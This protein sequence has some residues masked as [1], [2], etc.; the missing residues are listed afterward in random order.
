M[1]GNET[2]DLKLPALSKATYQRWSF[3]VKSCARSL[4]VLSIVD[5][6]EVRPSGQNREKE[7]MEWD[8]RDGKACRIL[9]CGLSDD[10]HT[11]IRDCTSAN[12]IWLKIKSMYEQRTSENKYLLQQEFFKL[13]FEDSETVSSYCAKLLVLSQK[14]KTVGEEVTDTALVSKMV[15]DLPSKYDHFK[16][17]YMIQAAAGTTLTFEKLREQLLI[18]EINSDN[19]QKSSD[20]NQALTV[21]IKPDNKKKIKEKRECYHC[22]KRG[23]L[24]RDC[25]K[26]KS[27]KQSENTH[28]T[29]SASTA[30]SLS[31][32]VASHISGNREQDWLADSGASHHMSMNRSWFCNFEP[33]TENR[34]A[35]TVGNNNVVYAKG[36]GSVQ[37]VAHVGN[38]IFEHCL[39]N[40]LYV[41]EIRCN[42]FSLGSAADNGIEARM[43][44]ENLQLMRNNQVVAMGSRVSD[45]LYALHFETQNQFKASIAEF[46]ASLQTWHERCGHCSYKT[47]REMAKG[48]AVNGMVVTDVRDNGN[49]DQF[50]EACVFGKHS[51]K[52]FSESDTRASKPAELIHF[53]I[54]G[55]MSV[56]SFG[57]NKL[58]AVFCDDYTSIVNVYAIKTKSEIVDRMADMIS[59]ANAAGHRIHRVRSDNAKEF[60]SK[61]MNALLRK[62]S[63]VHEY[64]VPYCA[65]QNGRIERQN[66]TIVEMARSMLAGA[67]LP[68]ELWAEACKTAAL[69]RNMLPL[70][71]LKGKTPAELWTGKKPD[72]GILRIYG[73]KA[74]AHVSKQ[75][76]SK[77]EPKS[78]QMLLVGY[79]PKSKAYR[80]W[81]PGTNRVE[82]SRDAIIVEPT[83]K[84]QAVLVPVIDVDE[85]RDVI[86]NEEDVQETMIQQVK[87]SM[88]E[89]QSTE[90]KQ[91]IAQRTRSQTKETPHEEFVSSRT[92]SKASTHFAVVDAMAFIANVKVPQTVEEARTLPD[93]DQWE[94]SMTT[95][96][97]ALEQNNT[98]TLVEP[99]VN[100]KP[101]KNK[102]VF[103]I[104]TNPDGSLDKYKA[105]LVIKGC[106]LRKGVDFDQTYSPVTR[107]E[108]VRIL[109]SIAAAN[110]FELYQM[111]VKSAFLNGELEE[112]IFMEQPTGFNDGTERVC[113]LNKA[114]YG[115]PQAPRAWNSRFDTFVKGFGLKA[116]NADPCVYSNEEGDIY[117]TLWVDDGLVLGRSKD[118]IEELLNAMCKEFKITSSI[119]KYYLGIKIERD[120]KSKKIRLTQ[121]AYARTIL[122]KFEMLECNSAKTPMEQGVQLINNVDENGQ[123]ESTANVPYR[124]IIGSLMYLAVSTRPDLSYV[125]GV[126]SRFLEQPSAS[127]WLTAKRVLKYIKGT[128][129]VGITYNGNCDEKN[130][131]VAFSDSD[132]ASCVNTRKSTSGVILIINGGPVVWSSRKQSVVATSTT[133]AEYI[134]MCE[135][136]KEVVWTRRLLDELRIYQG[137]ATVIYCDN[138]AAKLLVENPVYHRRTKHIDV[139]FHY[140]REQIK[141][142]LVEVKHVESSNQLA[143]FLTKNLS[144]DRFKFNCSLLGLL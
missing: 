108:S 144:Y 8:K 24:K 7:V 76:R 29:A 66:R 35:I 53:D 59:E 140:T 1:M 10:D 104:K 112:D 43:N 100:C 62:H 17:T 68:L 105:R 117:L 132:Y 80:L 125:V 18:I 5:G 34:I 21:K 90:D 103:R 60:T 95:E 124:Q 42:L 22:G 109:L 123:H 58:L 79:E 73:S 56:E 93:K 92:R 14:L 16:H 138:A 122:E 15:N 57:K 133:D 121:T 2:D 47:I 118:K 51:R 39:V 63:I 67:G 19:D 20:N 119:A 37:V 106:S 31:L 136:A 115:L 84:Q 116:T 72:V 36:R 96:I 86:S 120:R 48:E 89:K 49:E 70:K 102:W 97:K 6:S 46:G 30:N 110:D 4:G 99:P 74:Y 28:Q 25:R 78:K 75:F 71:R 83:L 91:P 33:I 107:L 12:Q 126:L 40:V 41:P 131:L 81:L 139:K 98:Y 130:R 13:K 141:N 55:P 32:M 23:H 142:G 94:Q 45:R 44:K 87:E 128:L 129:E 113:K 101:V 9:T 88:V 82:I 134:A 61:E 127:H 85:P 114:L 143:D 111:D 77:F 52:P 69:I 38:K 137:Q 27:E 26:L 64:S 54:C 135:A 65:A 11:A 50:C 3:E